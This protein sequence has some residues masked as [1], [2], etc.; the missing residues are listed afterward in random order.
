[1]LYSYQRLSE[2]TERY[3]KKI[4]YNVK[5]RR[6]KNN[7][8]KKTEK[9]KVHKID[10]YRHMGQIYINFSCDQFFFQRVSIRADD[11]CYYN[12]SKFCSE[13]E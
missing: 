7:N 8:K 2:D 12:D 9:K 5:E 13:E 4:G 3:K 11:E 10:T 6:E 1:M